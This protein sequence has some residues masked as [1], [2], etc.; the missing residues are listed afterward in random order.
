MNLQLYRAMQLKPQCKPLRYYEVPALNERDYW[1]P[2]KHSKNQKDQL[3][4]GTFSTTGGSCNHY[5]LRILDDLIIIGIHIAHHFNFSNQSSLLPSS[6][7]GTCSDRIFCSHAQM[8]L[9]ELCCAPPRECR[10]TLCIIDMCSAPPTCV[11][12]HG[13]QGGPRSVRSGGRLNIFYFLMG[14]KEHAKKQALF[15]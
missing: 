4:I 7:S 14:N 3:W 15:V 12:H 6:A 11:V 9:W 13:A 1:Q 2:W 5:L 8:G 10:T